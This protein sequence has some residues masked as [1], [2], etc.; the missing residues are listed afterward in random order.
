[1]NFVPSSLVAAATAT[2]LALVPA[3]AAP[4]SAIGDAPTKLY[5]NSDH[6]FTVKVFPDWNQVPTE[7]GDPYTV[8]KFYEPGSRGDMYQPALEIYRL[9]H[10]PK[11]ETTPAGDLD[12]AAKKEREAEAMRESARAPKTMFDL[13]FSRINVPSGQ[14]RCD[15][16]TFKKMVSADDVEGKLWL[17]GDNPKERTRA[18]SPVSRRSRRRAS[19]TASSSSAPRGAATTSRTASRRSPARSSSSTRR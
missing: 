6:K 4:V 13:V 16:A 17:T 18:S 19:S 10:R 9:D 1:M 14:K 5:H 11:A 7:V 15:A 8:A 2:L 12:P 3:P